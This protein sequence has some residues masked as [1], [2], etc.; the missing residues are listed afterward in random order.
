MK[1]TLYFTK[2]LQFTSH[3]KSKQFI[4]TMK[5]IIALRNILHF[6]MFSIKFVK[7]IKQKKELEK[8]HAP[9]D[10]VNIATINLK[11]HDI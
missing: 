8:Y 11:E 1:C 5:N 4:S 7:Q 9:H 2:I 10:G 6:T 3:S